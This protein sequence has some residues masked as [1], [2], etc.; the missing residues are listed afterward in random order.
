MHVAGV[1]DFAGLSVTGGAHYGLWKPFD[2]ILC[3]SQLSLVPHIN[4]LFFRFIICKCYGQ[5]QPWRNVNASKCFLTK[6][7]FFFFFSASVFYAF[8]FMQ[9][10]ATSFIRIINKHSKNSQKLLLLKEVYTFNIST[11]FEPDDLN[12]IS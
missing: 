11:Y 10:S 9:W 5:Q 4:R 2:F 1:D 8:Y 3:C 6:I 7:S 12:L